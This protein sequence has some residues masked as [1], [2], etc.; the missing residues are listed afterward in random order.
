MKKI[1]ITQVDS[2]LVANN[3]LDSLREVIEKSSDDD[4]IIGNPAVSE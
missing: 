4:D 1:F 2:L 3:Y